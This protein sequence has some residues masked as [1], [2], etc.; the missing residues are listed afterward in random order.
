MN[1]SEYYY[2]AYSRELEGEWTEEKEEFFDEEKD[3]LSHLAAE[4]GEDVAARENALNRVKQQFYEV[5]A[6][7]DQGMDAAYV[8]LTP[9][10]FLLGRGV[11]DSDLAGLAV[12]FLGLILLTSS[13]GAME[14]QNEMYQLLSLTV[15]G[16]RGI[17]LRKSLWV[18]LFAAALALC[19][20]LP[21]IFAIHARYGLT[22][23]DLPVFSIMAER[24]LSDGAVFPALVGG[25]S[26]GALLVL[27]YL[28]LF[29]SVLAVGELLLLISERVRSRI[30]TILIGS[31]G[32]LAPVAAAAFL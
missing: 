21:R 10:Q 12:C 17:L 14:R 22:G 7:R 28:S 18:Q 4:E 29:L 26:L 2:R 6:C 19:A 31:I 5:K 20:F 30:L 1:E 24:M 32:L 11:N 27:K 9:W 15:V 8:Y 3:R 13:C 23:E 25:L 16:R